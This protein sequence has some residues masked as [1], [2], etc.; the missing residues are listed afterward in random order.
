MSAEVEYFIRK[1]ME[2]GKPVNLPQ[3]DTEF[4]LNS[5]GQRLS[6]RS[7][8]PT[9]SREYANLNPTLTLTLIQMPTLTPTRLVTSTLKLTGAGV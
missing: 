3:S 2:L 6:C 9:Q 1:N 4:V 8:L 7:V 5:R